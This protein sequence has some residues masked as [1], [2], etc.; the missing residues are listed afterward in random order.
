L[1]LPS[2]ANEPRPISCPRVTVSRPKQIEKSSVMRQPIGDD[3]TPALC[4]AC[5]MTLRWI[6]RNFSSPF[7]FWENLFK[8]TSTFCHFSEKILFSVS[9]STQTIIAGLQMYTSRLIGT[10]HADLSWSI[11]Q[12]SMQDID[13]SSC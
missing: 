3:L 12:S 11:H 8:L 4:S 10:T 7:F 5:F 6:R 9:L 1:E 2:V 13:M